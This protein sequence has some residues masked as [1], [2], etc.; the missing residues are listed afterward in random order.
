MANLKFSAKGKKLI[1]LY[2]QMADKGYETVTGTKIENAYNDFELRKIRDTVAPHMK[3]EDIRTVLDYGCGG[4]DWASPQFE[5]KTGE[6]AKQYFD[7]KDVFYY[8]PARN[9][10]QRQMSDC[11]VNFDVLEHIF[12]S[13]LP[14][15]V[16]D[17]FSYANKMVIINVACYKAA[18]QL[19]NG[20]N[21]HITVRNP[22]WWKGFMDMISVDYP[23]IQIILYC[24]TG[25]NQIQGFRPWSA[26][27]WQDAETFVINL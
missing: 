8:E 12:I 17:I 14:T 5:P 18:A 24:S 4:S 21:A 10:D 2:E 13:D 3:H 1:Q 23:H 19:P 26:Q 22:M 6:S 25:Y 11:V 20:E 9:L 16:R 27:D 7:L 15:V